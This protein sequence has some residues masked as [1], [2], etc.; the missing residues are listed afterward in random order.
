MLKKTS[1]IVTAAAVFEVVGTPPRPADIADVKNIEKN[2]RKIVQPPQALK[3]LTPADI[4]DVENVL[5]NRK[6]LPPLRGLKSPTARQHPLTFPKLKL[7]K[8]I[9]CQCFS[10][11]HCRNDEMGDSEQA[12]G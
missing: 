9:V 10:N 6:M 4:P 11:R 3:S 1:E 8:C 2:I 7:E 12:F 5:K